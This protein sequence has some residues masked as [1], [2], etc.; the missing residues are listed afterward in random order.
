[1]KKSILTFILAS[2]LSCC[3]AQNSWQPAS[4]SLPTRWS[5]D[6]SPNNALPQYP[7]PQMVRANWINLNGLWSYDITDNNVKQP[8]IFKEQILVPYP[9]ESALSGVRKPL[10]PRQNLWYKRMFSRPSLRPNEEV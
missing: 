2:V 4:L 7:R 10:Q 9:L 3:L 8:S 1:M 5:T 6:V